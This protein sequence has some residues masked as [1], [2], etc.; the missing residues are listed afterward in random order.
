VL[1]LH[2]TDCALAGQT[3]ESVRARLESEG[4]S[5]SA[6]G[7][8]EFLA[9]PDPDAALRADVEAIRSFPLLP[10]GIEVV[11]WRFDVDHGR[12]DRIVGLDA[13]T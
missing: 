1:V 7:D 13:G 4:V 8:R 9:M 10:R 5:T 6:L 12:V 2:H 3:E 11:G